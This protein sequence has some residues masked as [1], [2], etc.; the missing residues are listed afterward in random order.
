MSIFSKHQPNRNPIPHLIAAL[1]ITTSSVQ[2]EMGSAAAE[3]MVR[4]VSWEEQGFRFLV[5]PSKRTAYAE[6]SLANVA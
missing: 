6:L 3:L 5:P 2:G 1:K 4:R